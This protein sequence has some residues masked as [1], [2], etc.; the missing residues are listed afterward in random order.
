MNHTDD[1]QNQSISPGEGAALGPEVETANGADAK[2][3]ESG[4]NLEATAQATDAQGLELA[5]EKE[6]TGPLVPAIRPTEAT[7]RLLVLDLL[8]GFALLGILLMNIVHFSWPEGTY[9]NPT[10]LYYTLDSIGNVPKEEE[11]AK[12]KS[13]GERMGFIPMGS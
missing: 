10:Y 11:K 5:T 6:A 13:P 7:E 8:R 4:S 12:D 3:L 1:P 9:S 2:G